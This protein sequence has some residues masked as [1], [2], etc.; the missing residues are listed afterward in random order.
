MCCNIYFEVDYVD[1]V[2]WIDKGYFDLV[3]VNGFVMG[4]LCGLDGVFICGVMG[5]GMMNVGCVYFVAGI[6]C[7]V[8]YYVVDES[9]V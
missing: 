6:C 2:V 7:F 4:V 3:I 9:V 8:V 5:N 1:F